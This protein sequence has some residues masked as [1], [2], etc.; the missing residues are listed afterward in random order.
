MVQRITQFV[1]VCS[2][3]LKHMLLHTFM[4]QKCSKMQSFYYFLI[5]SVF[6]FVFYF[7]SDSVYVFVLYDNIKLRFD[8]GL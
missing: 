7:L 1:L 8:A 6:V 5:Q 4:L 2:V 3:S